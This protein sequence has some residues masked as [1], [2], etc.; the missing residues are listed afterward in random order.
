MSTPHSSI[1]QLNLNEPEEIQLYLELIRII[2]KDIDEIKSG[3]T[4]NGWTSWAIIGG[5][6]GA[7]LLLFGETRKLQAFPTEDVKTIGLAGIFLINSV[8]LI[9]KFTEFP[10]TVT[11]PGRVKWSKDTNFSYIPRGI[12]L[13]LLLFFLIVIGF[14]LSIS[15]WMKFVVVSTLILW[16]LLSLINL[17]FAFK[18]IPIGNN[19]VSRKSGIAT[20]FILLLLCMFSFTLLL[21]KMHLP[22]GETATLPYILS[23]LTIAIILLINSLIGT[24]A[25]SRLLSNLYDLRNDIIFLRIEID[26]AL[27]RYEILTEG[28]TLPDALKTELSEILNDLNFIDYAHSNMKALIGKMNQEF[29]SPNDTSEQRSIKSQQ[30]L[31]DRDSYTLHEERCTDVFNGFEGKLKKIGKKMSQVSAAA[32]DW[33]S[34]NNIRNLLIQRL[35]MLERN[36]AQ[37]HQS[38]TAIINFINHPDQIPPQLQTTNPPNQE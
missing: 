2:E 22:M 7:L 27:Q 25:P 11:R 24:T 9:L 16:A 34:E 37:L 19:K 33:A 30:L 10:L 1:K 21:T 38:M 29:P 5:I 13:F 3:D 23:G 18:N 17:I 15:G 6:A 14:T 20:A 12:Y 35:Q 31:L 8:L 36:Q 4:K 28:E 26:E 32:E